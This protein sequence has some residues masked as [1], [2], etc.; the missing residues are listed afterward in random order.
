L[1]KA[2]DILAVVDVPDLERAVE[3]AKANVEQAEARAANT[4]ALATRSANLLGTNAISREDADQRTANADVGD[5]ALRVARSDLARLEEQRNF[6]TVRAPFDAVVAARNFDRGDRVRGDAATAEG[7]LYYLVRIDTLRFVLNATPDL[8]LRLSAETRAR[9]RFNEF[10]GRTFDATVARSSR[11]FDPAAGTMRVELLL[12]NKDLAL[13]A[14]L[15]GTATFDLTPMAG[16]YLVPTN[17]LIT[18]A[19]QSS[20]AVVQTGKVAFVDVLPGRNFGATVEVTSAALSPTTAV[21]INPNALLR[22]GDTVT[23]AVAPKS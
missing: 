15:T 6:A 16:T 10:P 12:G 3:S 2:G 22:A 21:I 8:A 14:G 1:V 18:R 23:V 9:V 11:V 17:T 20:L 13:P 19:G 5:A 4:R 7:W